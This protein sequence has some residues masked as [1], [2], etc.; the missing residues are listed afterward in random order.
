MVKARPIADLDANA[1]TQAA[2]AP[3]LAVRIDDLFARAES[4]RDPA[5][6][7][8]LHDLR[9]AGK[10]LRYALELS[11]AA[12][13]ARLHQKLYDALSDLQ[14]R[15]G[16]V[17]DHMSAVARLKEW[18]SSAKSR[19]DKRAL[20]GQIRREQAQLASRRRQFLRW[21]SAARRKPLRADWEAALG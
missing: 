21:W 15:L 7:E 4:A 5:D 12:L 3:V 13:P 14:E 8:A 16:V 19:E 2:C 6:L 18:R 10:R 9:I 17:C 20:Q 11:P 1:P